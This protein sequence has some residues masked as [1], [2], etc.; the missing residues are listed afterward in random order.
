MDR[1]LIATCGLLL[2]SATG[3]LLLCSAT[4]PVASDPPVGWITLDD[5]VLDRIVGKTDMSKELSASAACEAATAIAG[6]IYDCTGE[7]N[8]VP[9]FFCKLVN[10]GYDSII[11][12]TSGGPGLD[13]MEQDIDC[14][15]FERWDGKCVSQGCD[16]LEDSGNKCKGSPPDYEVQI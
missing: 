16:D 7:A 10:N 9:C 4:G 5:Q 13:S 12:N 6:E 1:T 11:P 8:N 3:T 2:I 14:T 15:L